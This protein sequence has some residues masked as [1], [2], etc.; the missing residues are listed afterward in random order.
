[1]GKENK[2]TTKSNSSFVVSFPTLFL[3]LPPLDNTTI[4]FRFFPFLCLDAHGLEYFMFAFVLTMNGNG[5]FC[6]FC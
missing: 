4:S 2:G 6:R 5:S 3:S 1:M